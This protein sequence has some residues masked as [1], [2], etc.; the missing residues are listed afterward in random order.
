MG[1]L[2]LLITVLANV[3]QAQA[4]GPEMVG[5][6]IHFRGQPGPAEEALVNQAGGRINK[7]FGIV[8]AATASV[9]RARLNALARN[10]HVAS[11]FEDTLTD[12]AAGSITPRAATPT[13]ARTALPGFT[14]A[15]VKVAVLDTGIDLDHP[16]LNV[17]G[18]VNFVTPGT[19]GD[20]DN[21]HGTLVAGIISALD[22][23][24]GASGVAPEASLYSVKVLNQNGAGLMSWIL[25]GIDWS[26][27]N[28]MQ[29]INMSLGTFLEMP[30]AITEA[31]ENA[32]RAG[33]VIVAA[34]GNAGNAAAEGNNIYS[35]ARYTPV[36]AVGATDTRGNRLA[37]SS[38]GYQLELVAPGDNV[39]ST[40]MEGGY[41]YLNGT[42][43]AAPH[44]AGA[45]A[46]LIGTGISGQEAR[47]RLRATATDLALPGW[48]S[49]TGNGLV[50][51]AA[52]VNLTAGADRTAPTTTIT[53]QGQP[54]T[55]GWYLSDV[56]VTLT[57]ADNPGG[58]GVARTAF[59]LDGGLTWTTY[60]GPFVLTEEGKTLVLARARDNAGNSEGPPAAA[61]VMLDKTAPELTET[62]TVP[63]RVRPG[64]MMTVSYSG[65]ARDDVSGVYSPTSTILQDEYSVYTRDLGSVLAGE[66]YI[67]AKCEKQDND[68][69]TYTFEFAAYDIAGNHSTVT[70]AIVIPA[71]PGKA[72]AKPVK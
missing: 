9:P 46:L 40:A 26:V 12:L 49:A 5:V 38:T 28:G 18:D 17:A 48:D 67:E 33:I 32:A 16:D 25:S 23:G 63:D 8:P 57:A 65:T 47:A 50:D 19:R 54:G 62:V 69:R 31:L 71:H 70:A 61:T 22:N 56:A 29:V 41:G 34:A 35:P 2:A 64:D 27:S 39:Y 52:A 7:V 53:L 68:G 45:A 43:A 30:P 20:D 1:L 21:G 59:S 60:T 11:V 55:F 15:G 72:P 6:I 13:E 4:A 24:V 37:Q 44:T 66:V 3:V 42:S 14:G 36:I 58:S 10:P 51:V